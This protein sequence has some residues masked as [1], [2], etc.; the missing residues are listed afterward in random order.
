MKAK[1]VKEGGPTAMNIAAR[2]ASTGR[3]YDN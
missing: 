3:P 2:L 1:A